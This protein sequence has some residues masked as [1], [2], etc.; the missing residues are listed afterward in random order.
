MKDAITRLAYI[1]K[2]EAEY[3]AEIAQAQAELEKST[4]WQYLEGRRE[5]LR[6]VRVDMADAEIAVRQMSRI[7]FFE[8][9]DKVPHPAVKIKMYTALDYT[10]G[11]AVEYARE[12][13]PKALKLVKR[14]FEKAAKVLDLD[15]VTVRKE[16]RVIIAR[17]LSK[18][19]PE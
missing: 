3:K 1:R 6:T 16:A 14:I 4:Q 5:Y 2:V 7:I 19:L 9:G 17:D 12:H 11:D 18:Y 8:T 10:D 15:F 13:L